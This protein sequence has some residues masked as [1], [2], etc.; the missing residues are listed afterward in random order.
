MFLIPYNEALRGELFRVLI[1][2][3]KRRNYQSLRQSQILWAYIYM[4]EN[5][6][7]TLCFVNSYLSLKQ[8]QLG[9]TQGVSRDCY[10]GV[11]S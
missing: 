8:S 4:P 9:A 7:K 3:D 10:R 11:L 6:P 5:M 1:S 2:L